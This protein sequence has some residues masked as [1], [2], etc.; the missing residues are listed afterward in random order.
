MSFPTFNNN[1]EV[2]ELDNI[3]GSKNTE[4][5]IY[6][7]SSE[8]KYIRGLPEEKFLWYYSSRPY[9]GSVVAQNALQ[10]NYKIPGQSNT[11]WYSA[12]HTYS[13]VATDDFR[14]KYNY[15][16]SYN[17]IPNG[18][19]VRLDC[20]EPTQIEKFDIYID[21]SFETRHYPAEV[22][23]YGSYEP[24]G[25]PQEQSNPMYSRDPYQ[26]NAIFRDNLKLRDD[27]LFDLTSRKIYNEQHLPKM[28]KLGCFH[29]EHFKRPE[30]AH[31]FDDTNSSTSAQDRIN[32]RHLYDNKDLGAYVIPEENRDKY[33]YYYFVISKL[34]GTYYGDGSTSGLRAFI[35]YIHIITNEEEEIA[36]IGNDCFFKGNVGIGTDKNDIITDSNVPVGLQITHPGG[37]GLLH[38]GAGQ[39]AGNASGSGTNHIYRQNA[40]FFGQEGKASWAVQSMSEGSSNAN[41]RYGSYYLTFMNCQI[42]EDGSSYN[43]GNNLSNTN[44]KRVGNIS[45]DIATGLMNNFTG[46]HRTFIDNIPYKD[47]SNNNIGLIVSANKDDFIKMSNGIVKGKDA[48]TINESLPVVSLSS[49]VNDKSVFG[50]ISSA[51]DNNDSSSRTDNYGVFQTV[52]DKE[53]GDERV[54]IN[55]LGEGAIWVIDASGSFESGDYITTSNVGGYGCKQIDDILHNYTVAKITM[56]CDFN[57]ALQYKQE[58][59][60]K[61][62]YNGKF[63]EES[64]N[65]IE[66]IPRDFEERTTY[67]LSSDKTKYLDDSG[68]IVYEISGN[69]ILDNSGVNV[70]NVT[71][72][73][74]GNNLYKTETKT[75][76]DKFTFTPA[77]YITDTLVFEV[78]GNV[79]KDNLNAIVYEI[80]GNTLVNTSGEL[81][82]TKRI[83]YDF[84]GN[85]LE[86][87][88][89]K[90]NSG[91]IANSWKGFEDA[92]N[93]LKYKMTSSNIVDVISQTNSSTITLVNDL[94][95][96][97]LI[98]W[99][100]S[101]EQ[102]HPYEIRYVDAAGNIL[103]KSDYTTKKT[104]GEAVFKAAFVG[105]TYHCG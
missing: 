23:V 27:N 62:I 53:E 71:S 82:T 5:G 52:V 3:K 90:L 102:E 35:D 81:V 61:R 8:L 42:N 17:D 87:R 57:P 15:F 18:E 85:I 73:N 10:R 34:Q 13:T 86:E 56:N 104:A 96:N 55:S 47:I 75:V 44:W 29:T 4:I 14:G 72:D 66:S 45:K 48:I 69:L 26:G 70:R 88:D 16:D 28:Y 51:E 83:S 1:K 89:R 78:S 65:L 33:N 74:S 94:D 30:Y 21:D 43:A 6:G 19:Y 97:G 32:Y 77:D 99:V 25:K 98:Q 12:Q 80:S 39:W 37:L 79:Y 64:N 76:I 2:F 41:D 91:P 49:K 9:S 84:S 46:Q 11:A 60:K 95:V 103:T 59:K 67:D 50:V 100:D 68:A 38:Q 24:V 93:N 101:T 63:I 40:L 20:S 92:S 31:H 7:K 36:H 105:C 22:H 54:F 58:I